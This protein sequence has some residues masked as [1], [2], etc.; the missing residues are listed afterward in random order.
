M[1]LGTINNMLQWIIIIILL[2]TIIILSFRARKTHKK[3]EKQ[4]KEKDN[5][6]YTFVHDIKNP[7]TTL[8]AYVQIHK[9]K[10]NSGDWTVIDMETHKIEDMLL[11]ISVLPKIMEGDYELDKERFDLQELVTHRVEAM[12]KIYEKRKFVLKKTQKPCEIVADKTAVDRILTNLI[13]NAIK[14]SP[15]KKPIKITV[16]KKQVSRGFDIQD[17]GKGIPEEYREKIFKPF[18]QVS[19]TRKGLGLG[20]YIC[21]SFVHLHNGLISYKSKIGRSTTFFIRLPKGF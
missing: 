2:T 5:A 16:R 15:E 19:G 20:L 7:L 14:Y 4:I 13:T 11:D 6:L 10:N 21:A 9:Q 18:T 12:Q 1:T 3:L 8:R 17:Y